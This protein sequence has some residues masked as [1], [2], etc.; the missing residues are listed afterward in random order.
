MGR[1]IIDRRLFL[2]VS[3]GAA[4]PGMQKPRIGIG[5]L[6]LSHSH[7]DGKLEVVRASPD[8]RIVAICESDPKLQEAIRKNVDDGCRTW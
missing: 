3:A 1:N 5:F 2:T 4:A 7:A 8:Y 6:G